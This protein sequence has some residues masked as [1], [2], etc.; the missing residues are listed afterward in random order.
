ML[1]MLSK[2]WYIGVQTLILLTKNLSY[3]GLHFAF[4]GVYRLVC[5]S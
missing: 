1:A 2:M 5:G 4:F 3:Y